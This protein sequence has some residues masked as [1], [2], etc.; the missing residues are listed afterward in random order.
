MMNEPTG[1]GPKCV[2]STYHRPAP[3]RYVLHHILPRACGGKTEPSNLASLC[4]TCHYA[5]HALLHQL[6]VNGKVSP[7]PGNNR[8]RVALALEGYQRAVSA[9]TVDKIP[10][11]G[12]LD[13]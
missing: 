11:E 10:N 12:Y 4:D 6:K 5:V 7:N 9:G 3:L 1:A 8:K 13:S 2:I